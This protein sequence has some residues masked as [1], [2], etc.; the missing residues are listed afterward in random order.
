M[1]FPMNPETT[2]DAVKA[3][4]MSERDFEKALRDAGMS[5]TVRQALMRD[6]HKGVQALRDAGNE[7]FS[8]LLEALQASSLINSLS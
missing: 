3:A 1:T 4:L 8:E 5:R 7:D 2:I 6:G